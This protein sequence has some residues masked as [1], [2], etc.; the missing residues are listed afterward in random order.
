VKKPNFAR[1]LY[2]VENE[3]MRSGKWLLLVVVA[4]GCGTSSPTTVRPWTLELATSGGITGRG[5]GT[6]RI[7]SGGT[8]V[9]GDCSSNVTDLERF[10][11]LLANARPAQWRESYVPENPC[12]DRIEYALTADIAGRTHRTRWIDDPLPMPADL[13]AIGDALLRELRE[14]PCGSPQ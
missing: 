12:C 10:D 9:V 7:D 3:P 1:E 6:I 13:T 2:N 11:A 4:L 14:R 5:L 8:A